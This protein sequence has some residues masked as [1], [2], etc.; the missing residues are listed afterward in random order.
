MVC[1]WGS[2][3]QSHSGKQP[4]GDLPSSI[5][6]FQHSPERGAELK[7][8]V[9]IDKKQQQIHKETSK[10][11][12]RI[13][14][15]KIQQQRVKRKQRCPLGWNSLVPGSGE[16]GDKILTYRLHECK[17]GHGGLREGHS[18]LGFQSFPGFSSLGSF[19]YTETFKGHLLLLQ[20]EIMKS[21]LS[22][23]QM[24]RPRQSGVI[25]WEVVL[26]RRVRTA[27]AGL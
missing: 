18:S 4:W 16:K 19:S 13:Q 25:Q 27:I 15:K 9:N 24:R 22:P 6:D 7:I 20:K 5:P 23:V 3:S 1:R 11:R 26:M 17:A 2:I 14:Y 21:L 12:K 8:N 10:R